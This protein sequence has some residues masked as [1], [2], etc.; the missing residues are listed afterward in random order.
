MN[1][2]TSN[3]W[4]VIFGKWAQEFP[5]YCIISSKKE[6]LSDLTTVVCIA[7]GSLEK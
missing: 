3:N 7:L 6:K 2:Y 5:G 4:E 1:I